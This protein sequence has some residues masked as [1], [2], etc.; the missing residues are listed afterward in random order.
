MN[1]FKIFG[2]AAI[3]INFY[4]FCF[5]AILVFSIYFP[6]TTHSYGTLLSKTLDVLFSLAT[7]IAIYILTKEFFPQV[8]KSSID[9]YQDILDSNLSRISKK[10]EESERSFL[11]KYKLKITGLIQIS[12]GVY[13]LFEILAEPESF[14]TDFV[15][16]ILMILP[17]IVS[18]VF[19]FFMKNVKLQKQ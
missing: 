9:T 5:G 13:Y 7:T 10:R 15:V 14:E 8:F 12:W 19:I 16:F 18:G 2:I 6:L 1:R 17:P 3:I 4:L 11:R